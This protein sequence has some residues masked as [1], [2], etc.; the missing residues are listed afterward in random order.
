MS[1][2]DRATAVM[3]IPT[4]WECKYCYSLQQCGNG[5]CSTCRNTP[6]NVLLLAPVEVAVDFYQEI[7]PEPPSEEFLK[8]RRSENE[9]KQRSLKKN[10]QFRSFLTIS[11]ITFMSSAIAAFVIYIIIFFKF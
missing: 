3:K 4:K 11:A 9:K 6:E 8:Q 2:E 5:E 10:E 1:I 7:I